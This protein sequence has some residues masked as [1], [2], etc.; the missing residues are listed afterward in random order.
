M[1][2][3]TIGNT[4]LAPA[5]LMVGGLII[6][7]LLPML[8]GATGHFFDWLKTRTA[9]MKNVGMRNLLDHAI[10]LAGQ[11]VLALE[12]TEV[13]YLQQ[14]V[15]SG[16]ITKAQ[17]PALLAGVKQ[18]AMDSV[19]SDLTAQGLLQDVMAL[20][21][22]SDGSFTKWLGDVVESHVAQLPPSGTDAPKVAP[23]T[24]APAASTGP[25]VPK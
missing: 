2:W 23:S 6:N 10:T 17:L 21:G 12:Q 19:K 3:Q 15:A 24:P 9:G 20:F 25:S 7:Y 16:A 11:K 8:P 13:A 5:L 22:G 18:K 14:Q 1:N 4:L